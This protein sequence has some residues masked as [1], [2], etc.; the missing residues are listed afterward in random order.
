[1][2]FSQFKFIQNHHADC[3]LKLKEEISEKLINHDS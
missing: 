1:M 3:G 2:Q